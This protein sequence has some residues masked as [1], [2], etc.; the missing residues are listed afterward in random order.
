MSSVSLSSYKDTIFFL[1]LQRK[2]VII[3]KIFRFLYV[4]Q[5]RKYI[6]KQG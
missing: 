4:M 2:D 6:E 3:F 5:F 1:E